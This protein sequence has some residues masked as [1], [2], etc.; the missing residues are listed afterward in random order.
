[1]LS[2]EYNRPIL[3]AFHRCLVAARLMACE[4]TSDKLFT[5]FDTLEAIP[6]CMADPNRN[7]TEMVLSLIHDC[8]AITGME[9]WVLEPLKKT[10]VE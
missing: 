8:A 3:I 6:M 4:G 7:D 5:I 10:D 2:T 1:M 9:D